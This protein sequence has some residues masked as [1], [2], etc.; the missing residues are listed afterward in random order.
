MKYDIVYYDTVSSPFS[1]RLVTSQP[2]GGSE[3]NHVKICHGLAD[4]GYS[5]LVLN[6]LERGEIDGGVVYDNYRNADVECRTLVVSRFSEP[7]ASIKADRI[8]MAANDQFQEHQRAKYIPGTTLVVNSLWHAS[9]FPAE[10]PKAIVPAIVPLEIYNLPKM[11]RDPNKFIYASA[12]C[13][14]LRETLKEWK[15]VKTEYSVLRDAWLGV[16]TA[17]HDRLSEETI[18]SFGAKWLGE[19]TPDQVVEEL[20]TAAGLF[21]VN[22]LPETFC[23]LAAVAEAVGC[24]CHIWAKAGGALETTVRGPWVKSGQEEFRREFLRVFGRDYETVANDFSPSK[25]IPMWIEVLGLESKNV[26]GGP[27]V[28]IETKKFEP[29]PPP[30]SPHGTVVEWH[31]KQALYVFQGRTDPEDIFQYAEH[32]RLAFMPE[33][34]LTA[35]LKCGT[36]KALLESARLQASLGLEKEALVTYAMVGTDEA[37]IEL[38]QYHRFRQ[39]W[40]EAYDATDYEPAEDWRVD[41]EHAIAAYYLGKYE[42]SWNL[43]NTLLLN[44]K[45]PASERT[46]IAMNKQFATDAMPKPEQ[47]LTGPTEPIVK[48]VEM[49][50]VPRIGSDAIRIYENALTFDLCENLRTYFEACHVCGVTHHLDFEWRRCTIANLPHGEMGAGKKLADQFIAAVRHHFEDYKKISNVLNK[51]DA[52]EIP[53]IILY[54]PATTP[55]M[56]AVHAD[57]WDP[58]ST[59]RQVSV[60][61]YLNDVEKGGETVFPELGISVPPKAGTL[62]LFPSFFTHM[63]KAEPPVSGDK[64]CVVTWLHFPGGKYATFPF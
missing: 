4:A 8:V 35:Y 63:H 24:R 40:Q 18:E 54:E 1:R 28:Y 64:F 37:W 25:V 52:I 22:I 46:R 34:A 39:Q 9:I 16:T 2:S 56:F 43:N 58:E 60:I 36:P 61:A 20:R 44:T 57:N 21:F 32:S 45:L 49:R 42:E 11:T 53:S 14:G 29:P 50:D 51:C 3:I 38:S 31:R 55:E 19:L 13:K 62:I 17:G 5:V 10:W 47:R 6:N 15:Q 41:D 12:V 33:R 59:S 23:V 7:P 30:G 26:G 48:Q 27:D